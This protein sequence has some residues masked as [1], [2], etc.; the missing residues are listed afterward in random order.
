MSA[1]WRKGRSTVETN[2]IMK[3]A[4]HR[5]E[6]WCWRHLL[7]LLYHVLMQ[8]VCG[9]PKTT[10]TGVSQHLVSWAHCCRTHIRRTCTTLVQTAWVSWGFSLSSR[11]QEAVMTKIWHILNSQ[12]YL[13]VPSGSPSRCLRIISPHKSSFPTFLLHVQLI[14]AYILY[15]KAY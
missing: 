3:N 8:L 7:S 6:S 2:Q 12:L 13:W 11:C 14:V 10:P 9:R 4:A 1:T 5:Y 15:Q